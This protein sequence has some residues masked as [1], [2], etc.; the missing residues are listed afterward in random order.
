MGWAP[1]F[2]LFMQDMFVIFYNILQQ[3]HEQI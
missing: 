3:I 2:L 1:V